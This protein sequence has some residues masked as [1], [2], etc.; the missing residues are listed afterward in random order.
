[1]TAEAESTR[2]VLSPKERR[3]RNRE[4]MA[5]AILDM[6]RE[7]M[8]EEGVAALN[9]NEIAR[10]IGMTTPAIYGYFSSKDALYDTLYRMGIRL[11][12]E[13]EEKIWETTE[14]NWE[15]IR[16]WFE[17]R[18]ALACE[19]PDLYHLVLDVPVPGF[20]PSDESK[21]ETRKLL[22]AA[23]RGLTEVIE[24]GV[25]DPGMPPARMVDILLSVRRG[26]VA[27]H[28]GKQVYL[29]PGSNRFSGLIPDVLAAFQTAWAPERQ[30]PGH[31]PHGPVVDDPEPSA[32]SGGRRG[33]DSL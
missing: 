32:G 4:E 3:Q 8:R 22:A 6:A 21:E 23:T 27:E 14:P 9:L 29:L 13:S 33:G 12:R 15:R 11:F 26:I 2:R 28:L 16:T 7:I 18:L 1:M 24:A 19:H 30:S 5:T 25:I 17:V 31:A 20:V 10:R